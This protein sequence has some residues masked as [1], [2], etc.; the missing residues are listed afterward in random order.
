[1]KRKEDSVIAPAFSCFKVLNARCF[2]KKDERFLTLP[3]Q[4]I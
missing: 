4:S 3:A 1:M 2:V